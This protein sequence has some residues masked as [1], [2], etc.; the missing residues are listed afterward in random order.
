MYGIWFTKQ[1]VL[2]LMCQ[3]KCQC[4]IFGTYFFQLFCN[5]VGMNLNSNSNAKQIREL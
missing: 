4:G 1:K 5:K 2:Y 3:L